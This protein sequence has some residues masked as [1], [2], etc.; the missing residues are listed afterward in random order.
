MNPLCRNDRPGQFPKSWY[1]SNRYLPNIAAKVAATVMPINS[2][3]CATEPLGDKAVDVLARDIAVADS[4]FVVN[5]CRMSEEK[6]FLFGG[7]ESYSI[8]FPKDIRTTPVARIAHLFPRPAYPPCNGS[9]PMSC[10]GLGSRGMGWHW[11]G[12]QAKSWPKPSLGKPGG[13][14]LGQA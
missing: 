11:Q 3:I 1:A 6:R 8:G 7:R 4:K 14:K 12:L 9:H 13:L 10:Q 2:F 5:H